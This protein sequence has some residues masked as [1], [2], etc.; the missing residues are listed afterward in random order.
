MKRNQKGTLLVNAI[1]ALG[2]ISNLVQWMWALLIVAYPL[3]TT[4]SLWMLPEPSVAP[5][6]P[7]MFVPTGPLAVILAA[8]ITL[9]VVIM[10]VYMIFLIPR[11]VGK[12]GAKVTRTVAKAT[13]PA[14]THHKKISAKE[15]KKLSYRIVLLL[16]LSS[17]VLPLLLTALLPSVA[18][19][20]HNA[21]V[22]AAIFLSVVT[23][24]YFA[25]QYALASAFRLDKS[26]IW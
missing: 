5:A 23:G 8:L 1:G 12:A 17:T 4:G 24:V 19:I 18:P 13:I 20:D 7:V 25:I 21:A 16:K 15:R 26:A 9:S 3:L 10:A 11:S 2:Y 6:Q 14:V 22:G